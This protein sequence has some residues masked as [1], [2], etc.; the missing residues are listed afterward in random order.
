MQ[1]EF[2]EAERQFL[3]CT[4]DQL[5]ALAGYAGGTRVGDGDALVCYHN[6]Q[7]VAVYGDLG[8]AEVVGMT[9]PRSAYADFAGV[10]IG[11]LDRNGDRPD[12]GD[13]G[14]EYRSLVGLPGG[15]E[16]P[17]YETLV[18]VVDGLVD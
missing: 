1:H 15:V 17:M 16:S 9:I 13:R 5:T 14:L 2:I 8:H 7:N 18:T 11:I 4:D 6:R 3:N 12:K 10:L